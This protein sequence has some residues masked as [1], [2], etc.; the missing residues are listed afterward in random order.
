M[1]L[2]ERSVMHGYLIAFLM[3]YQEWLSQGA[4]EEVWHCFSRSSGLC[5]Q[6]KKWLSDNGLKRE[7]R[8]SYEWMSLLFESQGLSRCYPFHCNSNME[9]PTA[10]SGEDEYF[11]EA[12][13]NLAHRNQ[14]RLA[15]VEGMINGQIS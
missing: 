7:A 12:Y 8:E 11:A 13:T 5:G 15:W 2:H 6:F 9:H 1:N 14:R 4:T 10:K 3:D